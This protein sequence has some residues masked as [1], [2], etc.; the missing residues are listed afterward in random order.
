MINAVLRKSCMCRPVPT[1][2]L[3]QSRG[4]AGEK[5]D[6]SPTKASAMYAVYMIKIGCPREV[7]I[8]F[9]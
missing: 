8:I 7:I 5:S 3:L 2:Y 9:F 4:A 6:E 1:K